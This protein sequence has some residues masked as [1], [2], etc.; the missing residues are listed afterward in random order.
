M[1]SRRANVQ[2]SSPRDDQPPFAVATGSSASSSDSESL[3]GTRTSLEQ[4]RIDHEVLDE[5]EERDR[6]LAGRRGQQEGAERGFG[7]S[8]ASHRRQNIHDDDKK[9]L[10]YDTEEGGRRWSTPS[11]ASSEEDREK[12][13][14]TQARHARGKR[15][16]GASCPQERYVD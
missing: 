1:T 8:R 16:V 3:N 9:E 7:S 14:Y 10:L 6:L 4:S 12:I 13:G 5:E 2:S 11:I 15:Q